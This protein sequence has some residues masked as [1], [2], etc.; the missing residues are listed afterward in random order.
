VVRAGLDATVAVGDE[1]DLRVS[2]GR[3][4]VVLAE[5]V[6]VRVEDA[7][8]MILRPD[9]PVRAGATGPRSLIAVRF[10]SISDADQ[11]KI[12]RYIFSI[13]RQSREGPSRTA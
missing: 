10:E 7:S 11:D 1:L 13:Q 9:E 12:V 2:L 6:V 8:T 3:D 5:A 4:G